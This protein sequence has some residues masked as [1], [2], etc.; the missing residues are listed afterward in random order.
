[1]TELQAQAPQPDPGGPGRAAPPA[2]APF[3]RLPVVDPRQPSP[4]VDVVIMGVPYDGGTTCLPGARLGPDHV[5]HA[6]G[7]VA[8]YHPAHH[9]DTFERL[10]VV[11]GGDVAVSTADAGAMRRQVQDA[12]S[13]ALVSQ[14][15]PVLVGGDH[16]ITLPALRAVAS[17]HGPVALVRVDAHLDPPGTAGWS[18]ELGRAA[19]PHHP[20]LEGLVAERQLYRIGLRGPWRDARSA[21]TARHYFS[22]DRV[23]EQGIPAVMAE[24]QAEIGA[25]PVYLSF[26]ID[27]IDPAFAPGT[28]RPAPGGMTSR[29]ALQLIRGL[30]GLEVVGLDLVGVAPPMDPSD[31]TSVLAAHL[32]YEALALL[33]R[34]S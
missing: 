33:A 12:V 1:M 9:V 13:R 16:A 20:Q 29:E 25:R 18:K 26:N 15:T 19:T 34:R 11:D 28:P 24:I 7:L 14:A 4:S 27:A 30:S 8:P 21:H 6:S 5:R 22:V 10:R 2:P 23:E 17:E 31:V 3:F 32:L